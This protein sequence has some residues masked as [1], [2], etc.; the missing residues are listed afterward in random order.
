MHPLPKKEHARFQEDFG[1]Q[2]LKKDR[3]SE[4][5]EVVTKNENLGI[6]GLKISGVFQ[7]TM[8]SLSGRVICSHLEI[9]LSLKADT[10]LLF[11]V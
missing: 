8:V 1:A 4:L 9:K 10:N 5:K 6:A 2:R 3:G 7:R 11:P